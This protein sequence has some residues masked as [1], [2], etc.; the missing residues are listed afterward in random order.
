MLF[1]DCILSSIDS[2]SCITNPRCLKLL[3]FGML[4]LPT[5]KDL[6]S[7][8]PTCH[9]L[10]LHNVTVKTSFLS[11]PF[12]WFT[13]C[14]NFCL[15]SSVSAISSAYIIRPGYC[16]WFSPEI[17]SRNTMDR[18]GLIAEAWCTLSAIENRRVSPT[19]IL[20]M[21]FELYYMSRII[22]M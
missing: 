4:L 15:S 13:F 12:H 3:V 17:T 22:S 18:K 2:E 5:F 6:G 8:Q 20:T 1:R 19:I 7:M 16:S 9:V 21:D 14:F 11:V 10:G